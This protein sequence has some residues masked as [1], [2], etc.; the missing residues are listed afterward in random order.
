[1]NSL[2]VDYP[3]S[4]AE[5]VQQVNDALASCDRATIVALAAELDK[6]NNLGCKDAN[7]NSLPCKATSPPQ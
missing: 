1:L 3:L 6:D 7:G 5:V 2:R 4:P